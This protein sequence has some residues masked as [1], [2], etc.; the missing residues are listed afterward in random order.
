VFAGL[1]VSTVNALPSTGVLLFGVQKVVAL[2]IPQLILL[3]GLAGF[4]HYTEVASEQD[5]PL[6]LQ[7]NSLLMVIC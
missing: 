1:S 5:T 4:K 6:F 2:G 7:T 3:M